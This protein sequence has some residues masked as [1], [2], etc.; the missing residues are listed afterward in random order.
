[1]CKRGTICPLPQRLN[2]LD[3][4]ELSL[5]DVLE[6]GYAVLCHPYTLLMAL[7]L[8]NIPTVAAVTPE[9]LRL[10]ATYGIADPN[11]SILVEVREVGPPYL[12]EFLPTVF[13]DFKEAEI[14]F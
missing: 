14:V 8:V 2:E 5:G 12:N 3:A 13:L 7:L 10:R 11:Q 9:M 1:M 6:H 4:I